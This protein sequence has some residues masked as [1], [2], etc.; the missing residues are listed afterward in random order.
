[1]VSGPLVV[2]NRHLE[3]NVLGLQY[4]KYED[5]ENM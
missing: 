2:F 1:M 4:N 3:T 5:A